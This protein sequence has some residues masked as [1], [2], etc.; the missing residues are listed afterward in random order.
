M[1][2][3]GAYGACVAFKPT[4]WTFGQSGSIQQK[5]TGKVTIYG[6]FCETVGMSVVYSGSLR[7]GVPY[8]EHSSFSELQMCVSCT[9]LRAGLMFASVVGL[10]LH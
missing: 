5:K 3:A 2:K 6:G 7:E 8:S 10:S 1:A 4:G 9:R